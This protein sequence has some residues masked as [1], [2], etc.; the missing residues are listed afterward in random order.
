MSSAFRSASRRIS[1]SALPFVLWHWK[2]LDA[3]RR[4]GCGGGL[5]WPKRT[6]ARPM[7]AVR[8][9]ICTPRIGVSFCRG[10]T[11]AGLP[12]WEVKRVSHVVVGTNAR[13]GAQA[14]CRGVRYEDVVAREQVGSIA[15][16][17]AAAC[18]AWSVYVRRGTVVKVTLKRHA[19]RGARVGRAEVHRRPV[20]ASEGG[21]RTAQG[22]AARAAGYARILPRLRRLHRHASAGTA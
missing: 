10:A 14:S 16:A 4:P 6:G 7:S 1:P 19:A 22:V 21:A 15:G 17:D 13:V 3:S 11:C 20:G 2:Q 8:R 12:G 18:T 9:K 5:L